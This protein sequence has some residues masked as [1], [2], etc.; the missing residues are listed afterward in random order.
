MYIPKVLRWAKFLYG[1]NKHTKAIWNTKD[2]ELAVVNNKLIKP[3][4]SALKYKRN[5]YV[6][7]DNYTFSAGSMFAGMVKDYKLGT[8]IGEPTG[9]LSSFYADP[10]MWYQLPNS[11]ITFQVSTSLE[12]RPNGILDTESILPDI[13]IK[14]KEDALEKALELIQT[15]NNYYSK[16]LI[17]NKIK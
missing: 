11:K 10:F 8:I 2:N 5:I 3:K 17:S 6:L 7:T 16:S 4:R 9:N 12:V 1:I 13:S 14:Y 15:K